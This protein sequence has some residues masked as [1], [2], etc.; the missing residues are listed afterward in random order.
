MQDRLRKVDEDTGEC[1]WVLNARCDVRSDSWRQQTYV[2]HSHDD[3]K[4]FAIFV[5]SQGI[6][7]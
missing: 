2:Q 3:C 4:Q 1:G 6:S 7:G 5:Y